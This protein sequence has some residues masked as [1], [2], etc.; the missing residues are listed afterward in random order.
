M[1]KTIASIVGL[2][3]VVL[4]VII[5]GSVQSN[6]NFQPRSQCVE[7][8]LALS[9]HIHPNVEIN[10][11]NQ[12]VAI[13]ANIGIDPS[14]MRAIH[15]HDE[16]GQMHVE[17]PEKHDFTLADFFANWQ[18]PFS[19]DRI[20]DKVTDETHAI[21]MLVDGQPSEEFENLVLRDEQ[22]IVI[23]YQEKK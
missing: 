9:M 22:K 12:K 16:S 17:Y 5:F 21:T 10:V 8:S 14:C 1:D 7:H 11:D 15:T 6:K 23:I 20:L 2:S 19:K 4:G 13:P 3:V 18:Q